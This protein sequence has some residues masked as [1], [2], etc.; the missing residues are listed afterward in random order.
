VLSVDL[1]ITAI[2]PFAVCNILKITTPNTLEIPMG[3]AKEGFE[4]LIARQMSP[5]LGKV[6]GVHHKVLN[7]MLTMPPHEVKRVKNA[8]TIMPH[9]P[10]KTSDTPHRHKS[11]RNRSQNGENQ[12]E[13]VKVEI[14][15]GSSLHS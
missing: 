3:I 5:S 14:L 15:H 9:S 7:Q 12:F 13:Q 6:F 1:G 10:E 11:K 8:K 2:K 4:A